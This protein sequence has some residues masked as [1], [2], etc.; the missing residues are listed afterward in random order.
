M[1]NGG[2]RRAQQATY[3]WG[4]ELK[5]DGEHRCN[6]WQ[7]SFPDHDMAEDGYAG[8]APVHA[9]KP[10]GYDLYNMA[11]NVWEWCEDYFSPQYHRITA[12]CD[13]VQR[14]ASPVARCAAPVPLP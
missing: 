8:T 2:A 5:P 7:G 14:A 1:G 6:I 9:Y 4:D 13:P 3:A 11:G 10:N 12:A